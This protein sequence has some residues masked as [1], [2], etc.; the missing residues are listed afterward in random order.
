MPIGL[1][2]E[3]FLVNAEESGN[4]TRPSI[5]T[6]ADGRFAITWQSDDPGDGSGYCIR[7]RI[8]NPDGTPAG[9]SPA[10]DFVTNSTHTGDQLTPAVAGLADGRFAVTWNSADTLG[11]DNDSG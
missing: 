11:T 7:S 10:S 9:Q 5:T 6:L 8:F 1:V 3:E 4:Q 2:G